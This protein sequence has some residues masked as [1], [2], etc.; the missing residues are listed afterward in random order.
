MHDNLPEIKFINGRNRCVL[1]WRFGSWLVSSIVFLCCLILSII[2]KAFCVI[3]AYCMLFSGV[4]R[5]LFNIC[6]RPIMWR[7]ETRVVKCFIKELW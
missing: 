7:A 3:L 5:D 1:M 4:C 6:P 2:T